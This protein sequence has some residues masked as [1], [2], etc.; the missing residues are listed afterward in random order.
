[1]IGGI[2]AAVQVASEAGLG[3]SPAG[4]APATTARHAWATRLIVPPNAIEVRM[5][6]TDHLAHAETGVA[7]LAVGNGWGFETGAN[8]APGPE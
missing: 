2:G 1:M 4:L 7:E 5:P 3:L 8:V 6:A